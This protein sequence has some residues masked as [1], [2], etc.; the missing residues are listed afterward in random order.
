MLS[1]LDTLPLGNGHDQE[2]E[3]IVGDTIRYCLF[4]SLTNVQPHVRDVDGRVIRDWIASNVA[5][6][7]FW[8][9]VRERHQ[10]TQVVWECKNYKNLSASD[11][12][13]TSYYMGPSMDTLASFAFEETSPISLII[14][15]ISGGFRQIIVEGWFYCSRTAI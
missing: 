4:R 13:Q 1:R 12:H 10:A 14:I 8:E 6:N 5:T 11:F 2:Y 7:G 3:K 15:S 9:M